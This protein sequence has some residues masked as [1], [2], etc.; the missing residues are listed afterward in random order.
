VGIDDS[1]HREGLGSGLGPRR[2]RSRTRIEHLGFKGGTSL[3]K[4]YYETYR[5]SE[6][7]DFTASTAASTTQ[8][9]HLGATLEAIARSRCVANEVKSVT[10]VMVVIDNP[11]YRERAK[12]PGGFI[13]HG[14]PNTVWAKRLL[15][16]F[17][18]PGNG[19]GSSACCLTSA[20]TSGASRP[21]RCSTGAPARR[22]N[23]DLPRRAATHRHSLSLR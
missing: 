17:R 11:P 2:H 14:S 1:R 20:S 12:A 9:S 4:C 23:A 16:A 13:E 6:D 7:L 5:Y 22:G 18:E 21:G 8:N 3:R 19:P 10:A 15:D